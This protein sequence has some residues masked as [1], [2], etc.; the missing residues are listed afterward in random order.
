LISAPPVIGNDCLDCLALHVML[1]RMSQ[2]IV[3]L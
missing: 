1:H 3:L 2:V